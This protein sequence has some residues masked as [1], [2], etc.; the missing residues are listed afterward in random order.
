[1]SGVLHYT[2]YVDGCWQFGTLAV[3][4]M[5]KFMTSTRPH[6]SDYSL[7]R[8]LTPLLVGLMSPAASKG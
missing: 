4:V 3:G 1:M 6:R 8:R 7:R 2:W 5:D